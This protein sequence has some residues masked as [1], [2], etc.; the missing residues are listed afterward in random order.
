MVGCVLSQLNPSELYILSFE[1]GPRPSASAL[2][3]ARNVELL[4]LYPIQSTASIYIDSGHHT[5]Q[6]VVW[7][8][9]GKADSGKWKLFDAHYHNILSV[10][11]CIISKLQI[12]YPKES[13]Q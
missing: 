5:M 13:A 7:E 10:S 9:V 3:K 11:L 2:F 1:K 4:G 12:L 8:Q 6:L